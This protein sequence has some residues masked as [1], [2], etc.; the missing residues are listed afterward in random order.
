MMPLVHFVEEAPGKERAS[1][2]P[3]GSLMGSENLTDRNRLTGEKQRNFV[4]NGLLP[5]CSNFSLQ[6]C[7]EYFNL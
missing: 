6:I 3:L 4:D 2:N 5:T 7:T 1:L